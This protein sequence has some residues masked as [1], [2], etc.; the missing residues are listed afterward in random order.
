LLESRLLEVRGELQRE[1][2][3]THVVARK[4]VDRSALLGALIAPSRDF[5]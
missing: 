2:A 3:V 5:H 1:G 4:L